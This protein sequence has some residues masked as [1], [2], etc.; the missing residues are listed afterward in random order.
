VTRSKYSEEQKAEALSLVASYGVAEAAKRTG[1]NSGTIGSWATRAGVTSPDPVDTMAAVA[2]RAASMAQRKQA[3]AEG[4][5][6]DIVKLRAQL[7]APA[8][9]RKVVTL[10]GG[11]ADQGTVAEIVD[12]KHVRPT[13]ADQ[14]RLVEAISTAL[15]S[16]QLLTGGLT[17]ALGVSDTRPAEDLAP[18]EQ[19][20]RALAVVRQLGERARS[21]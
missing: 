17:A 12:V 3:L 2:T 8:L 11:H 5:L 15:A 19:R 6:D 21:A 9:E 1:I 13:V 14:K 18:T 10:R 16:V 4:L 20:E 7:F